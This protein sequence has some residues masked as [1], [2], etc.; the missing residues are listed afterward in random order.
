[1]KKDTLSFSKNITFFL[2]IS[3]FLIH[4]TSFSQIVNPDPTGDAFQTFCK[5]DNST[6]A[7]L[8]AN[9][10][11]IVWF[12][13]AIG[14]NQYNTSTPLIDGN[15]YYADDIDGG[16]SSTNRLAVTVAI[17]GDIPTNVD[18]FVGKC[19]SETPTIADLSATGSNIEWF[20][21]QTGGNLLATTDLLIDGTT[22]WVQQTENGCVSDRLPT[23]VSLV[24]PPPPVVE[25]TQTFCFPPNP[26]VSDLQATGSNVVWY[27]SE[28]ASLPLNPATPLIDGEDYWAVEATFPCEST[29]RV[30]TTVT[31][32]AAPNAGTDASY[33]ECEIDATTTNL[34]E[35][36]GGTPDITGVWTGPSVLSGG[37]LGTFEPGVN[38]VG[39]YT[40]TVASTLGFCPEDSANVSVTITNIPP[41]TSDQST[42]IFCDIDTPTIADLTLNES[43]VVWYADEF[44]NTPLNPTD[45]LVNGNDYWAAL[46]DAS[47]GC[48]SA[49]RLVINAVINSTP[50]PTT[51]ETTQLFCINDTATVA[52]LNASGENL[53]W[54]ESA[55]AT[56]PLDSAELLVDG[57]N[58]FATQ[59]YDSSGCESDNRLE[60]TVSF[61]EPL[62][63][64]TTSSN[65]VF[66]EIDNATV[67]SLSATG[68]GILWYDSETSTTPLNE[69]D[70]L[71]DGED[72]WATQTSTSTQCE[73]TTRL[74]VTVTINVTPPATVNEPTQVFCVNDFLPSTPTVADLNASGEKILWYDSETST[75][76]LNLTDVL[77]DGED[78]W[79]SDTNLTTTCE[80]ATRLAVTVSVIDPPTPTTTEVNQT[81]CLVNNPTIANLQAEG[82]NLVWFDTEISTTPL[83]STDLLI[84]GED[85]WAASVNSSSSCESINRLQVTASIIEVLPA[86][87]TEVSQVFCA[88][89]APIVDNLQATGTNITWYDSE[90][91]TT[92]LSDSDLLIDG[93]DYWA[94]QTNTAS[95]CESTTR[96]MAT[97][98][99]TDPGTPTIIAT[100]SEFCVIDKPTVSELDENV[101]PI[102][103]G[104]ITWYDAYPN[105]ATV[106]Q[107]ELLIHGQTYYA[108]ESDSSGCESATPLA[109]TV[110][111][112][113]CDQYDIEIYDGFSP[114]G[115]G[116]NDTFKI[117]NL[118][119]LYPNFKVEFFNRWG[120]LVYTS[121]A[122]KPDWNG[123]F[124]GDGELSPAGVYYFIINFN[125][126]NRKP[127]QR[128]LYLS[129]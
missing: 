115:N 109:V 95:G 80:S 78:Y 121:D 68:D 114:S 2:L 11:T 72:Y 88:S 108:V 128:R 42:L 21:A 116:I 76:P 36:L 67:A 24:D 91:S 112:E 90:T 118:R 96:I 122:N 105:G 12:D 25:V 66:C 126:N 71:V 17:Y 35:L 106:N 94:V 22:Y 100:G 57:E 19:A 113:A 4:Q 81:F 61:T 52:D 60:V 37:Y 127:I 33:S 120:K 129:R 7:N 123:R 40:Y 79:V 103:G 101:A 86:T 75:T 20:D 43:N 70:V 32:D 29:T 49:T 97:V 9:G 93:E 54:Y 59:T 63:P 85:Y 31:L 110:S 98:T 65:Q 41:P 99:L 69:T 18:V 48:E 92:P 46:S 74:V 62:P 55:I 104:T 44:S 47:S 82:T 51:T 13:A 56:T 77:I 124:N 5:T 117:G 34:F 1:M 58:Y 16:G 53:Q 39:V 111:L 119:E 28:N 45:L 125:K 23:T 107:S 10:G 73:S 87:I 30:Q 3:S 14:G 102:N 84:D 38:T 27:E 83:N 8:V 50:P 26:T 89:D 6:V 15:I 64:T